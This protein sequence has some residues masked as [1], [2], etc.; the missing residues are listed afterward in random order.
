MC[1][2]SPAKLCMRS[3]CGNGARLWISRRIR[4]TRVQPEAWALVEARNR[5]GAGEGVGPR[6]RSC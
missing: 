1:G 3:V 5:H 6:I 2:L 4:L